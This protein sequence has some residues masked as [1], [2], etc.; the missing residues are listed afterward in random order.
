MPH[1]VPYERRPLSPMP[2]FDIAIR[3]P[4]TGIQV[5]A[6]AAGSWAVP[7]ALGAGVVIGGTLVYLAMSHPTRRPR[8][9]RR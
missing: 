4:R 8:R 3:E 6:H 5:A 1:L 9:R 2:R 7:V